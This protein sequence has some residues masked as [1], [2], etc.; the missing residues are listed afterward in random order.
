MRRIQTH[1]RGTAVTQWVVVAA[2][3]VLALIGSVALLGTRANNKLNETATDMA[4]P[5]SLT[6]RFGS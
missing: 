6:T 3:I 2:L 4:N 5:Q 1:R